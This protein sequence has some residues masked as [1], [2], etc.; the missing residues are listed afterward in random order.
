MPILTKDGK[1]LPVDSGQEDAFF[2]HG[3]KLYK[4]QSVPSVLPEKEPPPE[5]DPNEGDDDPS[6]PSF[7]K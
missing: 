7:L 5:P 3:W 6:T 4:P 1:K 2:L